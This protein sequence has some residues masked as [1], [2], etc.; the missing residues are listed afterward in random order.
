MATSS[1]SVARLPLWLPLLFAL[2][3]CW[4]WWSPAHT[5]SRVV[6]KSDVLLFLL[7]PVDVCLMKY[8]WAWDATWV[9][10]RV[11]T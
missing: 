3:C 7:F 2:C 9:G 6:S 10:V 11:W 8:F 1:L 5:E 4:W